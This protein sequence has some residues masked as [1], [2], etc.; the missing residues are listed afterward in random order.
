MGAQF[1]MKKYLGINLAGALFHMC[2]SGQ[3][4]PNPNLVISLKC[5]SMDVM[6]MASI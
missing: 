4:Y 2:K 3:F 6:R 5:A 1:G